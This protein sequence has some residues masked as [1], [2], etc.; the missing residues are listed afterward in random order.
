MEFLVHG[1]QTMCISIRCTLPSARS[2]SQVEQ[3]PLGNSKSLLHSNSNVVIVRGGLSWYRPR[4]GVDCLN[5]SFSLTCSPFSYSIAEHGEPVLTDICQWCYFSS[6]VA[7]VLVRKSLQGEAARRI[8]YSSRFHRTR[9]FRS[10][11]MGITLG[12]SMEAW[13][14]KTQYWGTLRSHFQ[15]LILT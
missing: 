9:F 15:V 14:S 12:Q 2:N 7:V 5:S 1:D 3:E 13:E 8:C 6:E 4:E 11:Q 10:R